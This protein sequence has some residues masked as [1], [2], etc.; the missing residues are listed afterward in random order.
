MGPDQTFYALAPHGTFGVDLPPTVEEMAAGYVALIRS[1]QPKGP[2][3]LGGFCNGAVIIY[4]VAQQLSRAGETVAMLVLLD[5]PDL[6]FF[7]L[8]RRIMRIGQFLHLP[9]GRS[10]RLYQRMAEGIGI[11]REEGAPG[12]MKAFWSRSVAWL[13]KITRQLFENRIESSRPNLNFHYYEAMG[14]YEPVAY[15]ATGRVWIILRKGESAMHPQQISFWIRFIADPSFA[16][17]SGTHLEFNTSVDEI[18]G[19]INTALHKTA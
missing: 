7:I 1:V 2:Y 12:F 4:E 18:S 15:L 11:W 8:R 3:H 6:F 9:E 19:I 5:P 10:R 17:V 16:V 14:S 13:V